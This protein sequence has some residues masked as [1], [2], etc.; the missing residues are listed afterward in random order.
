MNQVQMSNE[1]KIQYLQ[2]RHQFNE[3]TA[4]SYVEANGQCVYCGG[5]VFSHWQSYSSA[6]MD[7]ILPRSKYPDFFEH[8]R[9]YV[10]SCY[11]CNSTKKTWDSLE[12]GEDPLDM[13]CNKREELIARIAKKIA[14][15]VEKRKQDFADIKSLFRV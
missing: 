13:L 12:S 4:R 6:Q 11:F 15:A 14:G 3:V 5:D 2:K 10:L 7:H 9:N 1:E 8:P